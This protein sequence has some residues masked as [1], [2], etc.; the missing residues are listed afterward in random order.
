MFE[1]LYGRMK[2]KES[3]KSVLDDV[4]ADLQ[5][6]PR[7]GQRRGPPLLEE[8]VTFVREMEH[9]LQRRRRSSS[10]RIAVP[11]LE[12]GIEN[13]NDNMPKLSRMQ[14][15]LLVNSLANDMARVATLQYTNSVG[16]AQD[17]LARHRGRP[18]RALARAGPARPSRRKS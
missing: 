2:D 6:G 8:H 18:P 13:V 12:P 15:D 10:L 1:K 4:D 9:E 17:A 14:I 7:S 5:Q 16:K 11:A 3:L